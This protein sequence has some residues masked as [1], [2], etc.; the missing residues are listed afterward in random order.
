MRRGFLLPN[1]SR[2]SLSFWTS[3]G[4]SSVAPMLNQEYLDIMSEFSAAQVEYLVVGDL[5]P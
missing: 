3:C 2:W 1:A 4:H 5:A